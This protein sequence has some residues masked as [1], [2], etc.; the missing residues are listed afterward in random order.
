MAIGA[1]VALLLVLFGTAGACLR[2][3]FH[4][5]IAGTIEVIEFMMVCLTFLAIGYAQLHKDHIKVDF[6]IKRL[7]QRVQ[8]ILS[9]FYHFVGAGLCALI[10]WQ[11][12]LYAES[13][14]AGERVSTFWSIPIYPFIYVFAFGYAVFSISFLVDAIGQAT[15][16]VRENARLGSPI[17]LL[18]IATM[19]AL[20]LV[21]VLARTAVVISPPL[22]A[23]LSLAFMIVAILFGM[24]IGVAM[25]LVALLGMVFVTKPQVALLKTTMAIY[26]STA[27]YNMATLPVFILLGVLCF[28]AG[29]ST[30][31]YEAA[32]K[33]LGRLP[34]GLA[35]A[36]VVACAGFAAVSGSSV[37][38]A[39]TMGHVAIPEMKKFRYDARLATGCVAAGGTIG[40]LI[41]P[42]V[43]MIV[44]GIITGT[45]IGDLFLGGFIPGILEAI[46]YM[47][48][49]YMMSKLNP[50][51]GPPGPQ[52][53]LREK[54]LSLKG[55]WGMLLIFFFI[56]GGIYF[57]VVTPTE[58]GAVGAFSA[59][60][61]A[62]ARRKLGWQA[63][64]SSLDET[65]R[66]T[67]MTMFLIIG[68]TIFG[69]LLTWTRAPFELADMAVQ[70]GLNRYIV[71]GFVL[72][73]Y[74]VLGGFMS[75]FAVMV[76]TV[77][78]L[79]PLIVSLG[80]NPVWFGIMIVRMMEIGQITPPYGI[81]VFIIHGIS[82]VPVQ[83]VFRGIVPFLLADFCHVGLLIALPQI[84]TFL[85]GLMG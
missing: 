78:I 27:S 66:T 43:T 22:L 73:M 71:L 23:G 75:V 2:Y 80:F 62:L 5:P 34:G 69:Y 68:A 77:P 15:Q 65:A 16:A 9:S 45:S 85:P 33:W 20:L 72:L 79:F 58:A 59:L 50:L 76:I 6:L 28:Y 70:L 54:F 46:F 64:S 13:I 84:V 37:A 30:E 44:Y 42:S 25:A 51:M 49:I 8:T 38:T 40:A 63:F 29:V 35:M 83:T 31:L 60:V 32:Y 7:P 57:G 81:N 39:A 55:T 52:T 14:R 17:I 3:L 12:I 56:M 18:I 21:P 41:P 19:L 74:L 61:I 48:T 11:S 10:T 4:R 47:T 26:G 24:H 67:A 36:T 82:G 53:T 1:G